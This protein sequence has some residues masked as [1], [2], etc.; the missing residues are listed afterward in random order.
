MN[1]NENCDGGILEGINI[2]QKLRNVLNV[3]SSVLVPRGENREVDA[4]EEHIMG[5]IGLP[6]TNAYHTQLVKYQTQ[7]EVLKVY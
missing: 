4:I 2:S 5:V 3:S 6:R 1:A 7:S